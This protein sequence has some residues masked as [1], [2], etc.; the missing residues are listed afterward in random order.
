MTLSAEAQ[1]EHVLC[2]PTL[3]FHQIGYFQ[4]FLEDVERHLQTLLDP[5]YTSF[6]PRAEV[7]EDPSYKQLIPYCLFRCGD[8]LFHYRRG[9]AG[10]EGRL[11]AKRSVGV[12]GHI[13]STDRL[14]GD[15]SYGE[16]M[17]REIN[18][19]VFLESGFRERCVGMINDDETPVGRVHL[20]IVH[21]FDLD[22]AK[23]RPREASI[24]ESGFCRPQELLRDCHQFETWSQICL[25][26][27]FSERG[28]SA[29]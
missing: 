8:E 27:L 2:V 4:G 22:S 11:H 1:T 17:H 14:T 6:R 25:R 5:A 29:P 7:E 10:G 24:I 16:A 18:E 3:L 28:A 13:S 15:R 23:V 21:I 26:Q 12:G 20:G 19:E 9:K